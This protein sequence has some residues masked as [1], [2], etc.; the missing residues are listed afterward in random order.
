MRNVARC[1][2][3][4]RQRASWPVRAPVR[5]ADELGDPLEPLIVEVTH[6]TVENKLPCREQSVMR[7]HLAAVRVG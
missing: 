1:R 7:I 5:D 6:R 4:L 2:W 3:L